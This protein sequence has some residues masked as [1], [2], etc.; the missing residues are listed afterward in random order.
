MKLVIKHTEQN[1]NVGLY[2]LNLKNH[3]QLLLGYLTNLVH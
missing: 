3:L 2:G 1:N